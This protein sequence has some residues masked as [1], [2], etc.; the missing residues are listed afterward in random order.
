[1]NIKSISKVVLASAVILGFCQCK[2]QS[3]NTNV[4]P[5]EHAPIA[6]SGLKIAYIDVDSLLANDAFYQDLAEE[7]L[8]KQENYTLLLSEERNKIEN[9]IKDFNNK[10]EHQVYSSEE[11]RNAEYNRIL[12]RQQA[13]EDKATK[14]SQELADENNANS[15]KI[16]E[17]VENYIKEYNK[18]HGYNLI[19]SKTSLLFADETLNV[20]AEVLEGLNAAYNQTSK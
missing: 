13:L 6:L 15:Q 8:R 16:G 14:Y 5:Q 7:I 12:K 4:T 3:G 10:V 9:D 11:R 19:I 17:T 1:M 2:Q 20:T 18:S